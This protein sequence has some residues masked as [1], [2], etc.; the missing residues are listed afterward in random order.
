MPEVPEPVTNTLPGRL[1]DEIDYALKVTVQL[2][3]NR[4]DSCR[5]LTNA[6]AREIQE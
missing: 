1:S 6:V 5:F 3:D 4:K 2:V